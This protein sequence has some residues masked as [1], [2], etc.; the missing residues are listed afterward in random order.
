M[1]GF[2]ADG[3]FAGKADSAKGDSVTSAPSIAFNLYPEYNLG[4]VVLGAD[5]TFG[6]QLGSDDDK[7][8]GNARKLFGLGVYA[9]KTFG[10]GNAR[11]G[12]YYN[13][14]IEEGEF[15]GMSFPM[16]ITYSF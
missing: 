15:W 8:N 3:H 13:A 1:I 10:H 9:H 7:A 11:A 12:I 6:A 4:A 16:W 2:A 5:I 14:P